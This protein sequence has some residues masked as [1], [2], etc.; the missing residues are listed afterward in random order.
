MRMRFKDREY[1]T[2]KK[3]DSLNV[4]EQSSLLRGRSR[5]K[6]HEIHTAITRYVI[7]LLWCFFFFCILDATSSNVRFKYVLNIQSRNIY[8]SLR[9]KVIPQ[10]LC[11]TLNKMMHIYVHIKKKLFQLH[12]IKAHDLCQVFHKL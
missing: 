10:M 4:D 2:V 5:G 11:T 6:C 8:L 12:T 9:S 3:F 1:S 7:S